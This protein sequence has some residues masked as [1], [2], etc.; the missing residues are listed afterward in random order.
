MTKRIEECEDWGQQRG[1]STN[2]YLVAQTFENVNEK[3]KYGTIPSIG[4]WSY[5]YN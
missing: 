2:L 4:F 3:S 5:L 1:M